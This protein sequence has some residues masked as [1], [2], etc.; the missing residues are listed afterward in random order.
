MKPSLL[1]VLVLGVSIFTGYAGAEE[2]RVGILAD[3]SSDFWTKLRDE[4]QTAAK[5]LDMTLDFRVP[6]PPTA[7]QQEALAQK[8]IDAGVKALAICPAKA[9][10]QKDF[11]EALAQRIPVIVLF[12]EVPNSTDLAFLGK[13]NRE[14]GRLLATLIREVV[15]EGLKI[16]V[17]CDDQTRP[18]TQQRIESFREALGSYAIVDA[19]LEDKGDRML[20]WANVIDSLESRPEIAAFVGMQDYHGPMILRAVLEKN[21]GKW[22]RVVSCGS[23]PSTLKGLEDGTV[24]GLVVDDAAGSAQAIVK[25]LAAFARND[26]EGIE[27]TKVAT[28]PVTILKTEGTLSP[29]DMMNALQLQV[30]WVS[31]ATPDRP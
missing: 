18:A 9:A 13:D 7:E 31:E 16:Q 27:E 3:A 10:K 5:S 8:M 1:L 21:R 30:P 19:V 25:G 23:D 2:L 11:L 17:L 15:P 20:G 28:I 14:S 12:K 26:K 29:E 4:A 22:V 24:H 6:A